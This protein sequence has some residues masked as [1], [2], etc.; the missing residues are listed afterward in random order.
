MLINNRKID[1]KVYDPVNAKNYEKC[2][3][4]LNQRLDKIDRKSGDNVSL[5][6]KL[7]CRAIRTFFNS[8]FKKDV[9]SLIFS[10]DSTY[11]EYFHSVIELANEAKKERKKIY[12]VVIDLNKIRK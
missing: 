3:L 11:E 6:Y 10:K 12:G 1:F 2:M 8:L 9:S 5:K 7:S 4:K